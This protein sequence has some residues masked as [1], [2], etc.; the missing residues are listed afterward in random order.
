V[1]VTE[2]SATDGFVARIER[3]FGTGVGEVTG[4]AIL[5]LKG[6]KMTFNSAD[7]MLRPS[8]VP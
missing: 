3:V 5:D 8:N 1:E 4:G 2:I 7:V 6:Q